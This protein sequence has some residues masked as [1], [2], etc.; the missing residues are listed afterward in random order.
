M[1]ILIKDTQTTDE[2]MKLSDCYAGVLNGHIHIRKGRNDRYHVECEF[3]V[4]PSEDARRQGFRPLRKI[5]E[6]ALFLGQ[7]PPY[8]E[9]YDALYSKLKTEWYTNYED[10]LTN[11]ESV[12]EETAGQE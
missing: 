10:V 11:N 2:G 12:V 7:L 1:G 4:W 3:G 8:S 6:V 9:V 5:G